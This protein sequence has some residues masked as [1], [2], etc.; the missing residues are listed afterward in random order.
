M[1]LQSQSDQIMQIFENKAD[2]N[3]VDF[4][5]K[6]FTS[7][8]RK[9]LVRCNETRHFKNKQLNWTCF[10]IPCK[11]TFKVNKTKKVEQIQHTLLCNIAWRINVLRHRHYYTIKK[12]KYL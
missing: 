1:L 4:E 6:K 10:G 5:M 11:L 2:L 8:R 9:G 3:K 7:C 12:T